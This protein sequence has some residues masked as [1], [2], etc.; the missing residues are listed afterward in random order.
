VTVPVHHVLV[1]SLLLFG[2]G[3]VGVMIRRNVLIVLM[4]V[5]L[6]LNA[7]NLNFIAFSRLHGGLGGQIF[8][9]FVIVLAAGEAA[10]GLAILIAFF[11]NRGTVNLQEA[12]LLKG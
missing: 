11:R 10:V 6:M 12:S 9:V 3:L 2:I 8:A 1:V 7:A 4:S 5:E